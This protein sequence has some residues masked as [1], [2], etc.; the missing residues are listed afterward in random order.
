MTAPAVVQ[1]AHAH[2]LPANVRRTIR[3]RAQAA[4]TLTHHDTTW[5]AVKA[6]AAT[7]TLP[8]G[9]PRWMPA[10]LTRPINP[11]VVDAWASA[12]GHAHPWQ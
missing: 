3:A 8:D 11:A 5:A 10:D 6:W 4:T 12:H 9:R 2:E 1:A 7:Q